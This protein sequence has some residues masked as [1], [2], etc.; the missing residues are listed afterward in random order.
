MKRTSMLTV[1]LV[2][3]A[4]IMSMPI[5]P[6]LTDVKAQ[7]GDTK[8]ETQ[9]L[10]LLSNV[11]GIDASKYQITDQSY[12]DN[13]SSNLG[14]SVQ[15]E[16]TSFTLNSSDGSSISAMVI[17]DNGYVYDAVFDL[18]G[19]VA[20]SQQLNVSALEKMENM[21][22]RYQNYTTKLGVSNDEVPSALT[23]LSSVKQLSNLNLTEGNMKMEITNAQPQSAISLDYCISVR[24][25]Y[26]ANGIDDNW[27]CLSLSFS[28]MWGE[29]KIAF[30][31]TW[32]LFSVSSTKLPVLSE[33]DA[34]AIA[35]NAAKNYQIK[36]VN[37]N[38]NSTTSVTPVW[39]T[40]PMVDSSIVTV[41][42][43]AYNVSQK[44]AV[45]TGSGHGDPLTLYPLWQFVF[46]FNQSIGDNVG[47]QVGVWA[48]TKEIAYCSTYGYFGMP[49][50]SP[51][52]SPVTPAT[53]PTTTEP[54]NVQTIALFAISVAVAS[55]ATATLLI[56][57]KKRKK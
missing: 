8:T 42:G 47:T 45:N 22:L 7:M 4:V 13:A 33:N 43:Q 46:Y 37:P 16:D 27:K 14:S 34:Q 19:P 18:N 26:T 17:F 35:W 29:T 57:T 25:V 36:M 5:V 30:A 32:G 54:S 51:S 3:I 12:G 20:E 56:I 52:A 39:P 41:P 28:R 15:Q 49:A 24:W 44:L 6:A 48:D 50:T 1:G 38:D 31:D 40:T 21:I 10:G 55:A 53:N 11:V 2:C 9:V 23:M